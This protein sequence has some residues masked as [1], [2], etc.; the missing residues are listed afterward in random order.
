MP[1][2]HFVIQLSLYISLLENP[3]VN[4]IEGFA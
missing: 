3:Q 1:Y 2:P 4:K